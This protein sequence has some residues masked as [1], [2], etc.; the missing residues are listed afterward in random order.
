MAPRKVGGAYVAWCARRGE[1]L[2]RAER[3]GAWPRAGGRWRCNPAPDVARRGLGG[4]D[5]SGRR[6]GR[7]GR[8]WRGLAGSGSF[9][10]TGI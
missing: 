7:G 9:R 8:F 3:E 10:R 1:A 4:G 2:P 6:G 5:W